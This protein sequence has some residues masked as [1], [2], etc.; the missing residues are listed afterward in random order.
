M[1]PG[2]LLVAQVSVKE[3]A[4]IGY[5]GIISVA[6]Y[7]NTGID[8]KNAHPFQ[9]LFQGFIERAADS[10]PSGI[11]IDVYR[12]FNG[13]GI[14]LPT[15][16]SMGIGITDY[17]AVFFLPPSTDTGQESFFADVPFPGRPEPDTQR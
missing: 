12:R 17:L 15:I 13:P 14:G 6:G 8:V 2:H 5:I 1:K 7:G 16:K 3:E 9:S 4:A 11:F 10:G